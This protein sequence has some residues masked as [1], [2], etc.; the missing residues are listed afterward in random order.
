MHGI[1]YRAPDL[2]KG[3][4][5]NSLHKKSIELMILESELNEFTCHYEFM[6]DNFYFIFPKCGNFENVLILSIVVITAL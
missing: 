4:S 2:L 3:F 1:S 6:F 5:K